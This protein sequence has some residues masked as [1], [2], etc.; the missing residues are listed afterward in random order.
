MKTPCIR[1][2]EIKNGYCIGC[3]RSI[4]EIADWI[5]LSD[6]D[7]DKIMLDLPLRNM[8]NICQNP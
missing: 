2:C 8:E 1:I 3:K 7:R 4:S 6:K 5:N